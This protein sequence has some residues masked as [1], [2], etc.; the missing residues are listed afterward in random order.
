MGL[1]DQKLCSVATACAYGPNGL[2][3][4]RVWLRLLLVDMNVLESRTSSRDGAGCARFNGGFRM[5]TR[6]SLFLFVSSKRNRCSVICSGA[7]WCS[8]HVA[9]QHTPKKHGFSGLFAERSDCRGGAHLRA[10]HGALRRRVKNP[11]NISTCLH[12]V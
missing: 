12:I 5:P 1:L 3:R 4:L 8:S 2:S 10:S 6:R 11:L 9:S 7:I